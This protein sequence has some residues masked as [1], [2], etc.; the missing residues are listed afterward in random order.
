MSVL[1]PSV[2][3]LAPTSVLFAV[4]DTGPGI[5]PEELPHVFDRYWRTDREGTASGSGLGL[6]IA[7]QLVELHG[8]S[9]SATGEPGRGMTFTI[10][11]PV[12]SAPAN[13]NLP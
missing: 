9:I 11:L 2:P 7:R 12:D 13:P 4:S 3:S 8:G 10:E 6:A 1:L 5:T